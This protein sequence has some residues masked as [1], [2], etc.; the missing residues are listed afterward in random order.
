VA[1]STDQRRKEI[2]I[3]KVLGSSPGRLLGLFLGDFSKPILLS[4]LAAWPIAFFL[5]HAWLQGF[6]YRMNLPF[7]IFPLGGVLAAI[8]AFLTIEIQIL[9]AIR[10]NPVEI[11][12]YE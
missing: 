4:N 9:R 5:V 11:L 10:V 1:F 3:R 7:W 8:I 2:G 12:R 6:A